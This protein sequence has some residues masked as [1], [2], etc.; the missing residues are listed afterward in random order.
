MLPLAANAEPIKLKFAFFASDREFAFRG[1]VKP[2]VDAVNLEGKG[3]VEIELF[4]GGALER[5]YAKQAQLVLSGGADMAWIHTALTPEQFP[6]NAVIELPGLFQD[7]EEATQVYSRVT[8][9]GILRGYE[10]FFLIAALGTAPLAIHMRTSAASLADLK[11]KKIRTTNRTEAALLKALGMEPESIPIN[12]TSD[13]I[14]QGTIDGATAALEA[15]TDFGISRFATS[16]YMLGLGTVPL[17]IAMNKRKFDSLPEAAQNVIRKYSGQWLASRYIDTV[18]A[19]DAEILAQF[20]A[21]PRRKVT[22][23]SPSDLAK[24][25]AAFNF[26]VDQ[27]TAKGPRNGELL[28]AVAAELA[29]F[30]STR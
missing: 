28:Q 29:R 16:H 3:I 18:N 5:S 13:A 21:D 24:A 19:Y 23:P 26:I 2:F 12:Q 4:P 25:H 9:A 27:W 7:A 6:D 1:V 14:N 15:V 11:G 30:R 8:A 20:N 22:I 10:G 17:I